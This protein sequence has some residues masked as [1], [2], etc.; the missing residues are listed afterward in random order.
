MTNFLIP[1]TFV[2]DTEV[3][4]DVFT[5]GQKLQNESY[6]ASVSLH[7]DVGL[8]RGPVFSLVYPQQCL[9]CNHTECAKTVRKTITSK[10]LEIHIESNI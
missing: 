1:A 4:C 10:T 3:Y 5:E 7:D 6:S 8:L 9:D 2:K